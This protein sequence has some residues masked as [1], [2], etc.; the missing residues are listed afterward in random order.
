[1]GFYAQ[2]SRYDLQDPRR[3]DPPRDFRAACELRLAEVSCRSRARG[4]GALMKTILVS[5]YHPLLVMLHWLIAVLIV[6]MLCIGFLVLEPMPNIDPQKISILLIHMSVGMAILAVMVVRFVVRMR[7]SR[8]AQATTG[9]Q[10]LDRIA[11]VTH[12]GFYVLVLLMV[13]SASATAILPGLNTSVFQGTGEALPPT[14]DIYPSLVAHGYIALLL[15]G[16][17]ILHVLAALYHQFVRK[18]GLLQ[19]FGR[20]AL[21]PSAG[22]GYVP[23][24]GRTPPED[25]SF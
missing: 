19:R 5:R 22:A 8:P 10:L 9:N 24:F 23:R 18:D 11:P 7:S 16:F 21:D 25:P 15:A 13:G 6:A 14:V 1:M 3:S 2:R 20:R 12:Y 17:I 4:G